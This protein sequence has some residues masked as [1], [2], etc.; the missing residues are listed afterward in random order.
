MPLDL[1]PES[2]RCTEDSASVSQ[3]LLE[4]VAISV[5]SELMDSDQLDVRSAIVTLLDPSEMIVTNNLD[6]ASAERRVSMEDNVISVNLD[7][8]DS[9]SAVLASVTTT[10]TFVI[11]L[12]ERVLNAEILPPDTTVIDAKM[13]I[14]EIQD[15]ES[16]FHVS[17]VH[18]QE[19]QPVDISML[20]LAILETLETTP[21]ISFVTANPD[22]KENDAESA[23]RII[24]DRHVRLE[25]LAN[26]AIVTETLIWLWKEVVMLPLENVS[27][28]F[29]IPRELNASI[30]LMDIMEMPS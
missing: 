8:G 23:P 30:V 20:T 18:V 15:S 26:V 21:R 9:Q 17:H 7:S 29:T 22:T 27:N 14:M 1:Y 2:V 19:D 25:E 6:S 3:M 10:P 16:V 11:R 28:V 12:V 13:D 4:D 24:G 5:P